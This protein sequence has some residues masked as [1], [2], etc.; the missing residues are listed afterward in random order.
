MFDDALND[1]TPTAETCTI[2]TQTAGAHPILLMH[3]TCIAIFGVHTIH[4]TKITF[5]LFV[6]FT[7]SI[8]DFKCTHVA[9]AKI[10]HPTNNFN[11]LLYQICTTYFINNSK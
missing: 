11:I 3:M 5:C 9:H 8:T 1:E 4:G 10:R 6:S 7:Q 2:Y